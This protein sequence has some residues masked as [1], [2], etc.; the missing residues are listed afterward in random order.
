MREQKK[1]WFPF[2]GAFL[3]LLGVNIVAIIAVV[4]MVSRLTVPIDQE[5]FESSAPVDREAAFTI[6][7]SK[8]KLNGLIAKE[9]EKEDQGVPYVV[10]IGDELIEFRSAF[11]LFGQQIPVQMSFDPE[12]TDNGDIVLHAE[13]IFVSVFEM[14]ADRAMQ[15]IKDFTDMPEWVEIYP[16]DQLAHIKVTEIDVDPS[17]EF[18]AQT[19]NIAED[20]FVF[21]MILVD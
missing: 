16:A 13:Q 18:R 19:I 8:S 6:E 4:V 5:Y 20:Q 1:R 11:E 10:E 3:V 21:E 12:V 15:I 2:K 9:I 14:P 7:T 17:I